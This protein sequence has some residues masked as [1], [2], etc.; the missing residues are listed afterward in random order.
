MKTTLTAGSIRAYNPL[1]MANG[2]DLDRTYLKIIILT[3]SRCWSLFQVLDIH[4]YACGLKRGSALILNQNFY[5]EMAH[6]LIR[7]GGGSE[8]R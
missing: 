5:F 2:V 4:E 6:S 1:P 8:F 3:Q 7:C